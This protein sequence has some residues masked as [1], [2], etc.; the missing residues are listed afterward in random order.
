MCSAHVVHEHYLVL[1]TRTLVHTFSMAN[2]SSALTL[3]SRAF[4]KASC[5]MKATYKARRVSTLIAAPG[6]CERHTE[7]GILTILFISLMTSSSLSGRV[8]IVSVCLD[9]VGRGEDECGDGK[10]DKSTGPLTSLARL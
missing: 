3:T 1:T 5:L 9:A 2:S 7:R 6:G 4:S 8:D 10:R